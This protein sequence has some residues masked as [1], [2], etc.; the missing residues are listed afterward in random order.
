MAR[1]L[2]PKYDL[3]FKRIFGEHPHLLISF[4][5]ALMPFEAGRN[6]VSI[7]YLPSELIPMPGKKLSIVDVRCKDN[8][9][10]LF[11]VE[12]QIEWTGEFMNRLYFNS[13]KAYVKP[14]LKGERYKLLNTVYTLVI[15]NDVFD[16]VTDRF[17]HHF[18]MLN[19]EN[20]AEA[21]EGAE[22][23]I[24]EIP[25]FLPE[26]MANRKLAVLWLRFLT[27]VDESMRKLPSEMLEN[28]DIR[29]ALELC[30]EGA[31][32]EEELA[33]YYGRE[34]MVRIEKALIEGAKEEGEAIGLEK[35][36]AEGEAERK[37]LEAKIEAMNANTVI[38]S[39]R[40]GIPPEIIAK[41][42][43]LTV[44]QILKIIDDF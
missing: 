32:T 18:K 16:K 28:D 26:K 21:V 20:S 36:K 31:F 43:G 19:V 4:L 2:D 11:I 35:G 41:I 42:T 24:L 33:A 7:E 38:S 1:Y 13:C 23:I 15:L 6:I 22:I 27:E 39:H 3:T 34:D 14:L 8:Y 9:G 12:M 44:E 25:K 29:T 17:Y 10:R 40:A 37:A 30:E 5:N